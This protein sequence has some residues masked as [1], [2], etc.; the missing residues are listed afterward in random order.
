MGCPSDLPNTQVS[1]YFDSG[2]ISSVQ[3]GLH[4]VRS[5][6]IRP[7]AKGEGASASVGTVL[8]PHRPFLDSCILLAF[9]RYPAVYKLVFLD[10]LTL[11][12]T[13]AHLM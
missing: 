13:D 5:T 11:K 4:D 8:H 9:A 12:Y 6:N 1:P 2:G 7:K 10:I 3:N